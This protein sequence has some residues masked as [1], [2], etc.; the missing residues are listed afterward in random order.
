MQA[1]VVDNGGDDAAAEPGSP[2]AGLGDALKDQSTHSESQHDHDMD[3]GFAKSNEDG[4]AAE[5]D[6]HDEQEEEEKNQEADEQPEQKDMDESETAEV[7]AAKQ[8]WKADL[9]VL[10][11]D[12]VVVLRIIRRARSP[13]VTKVLLNSPLLFH[14]RKRVS[15]A[16]C[17]IIPQ[18]VCGPKLF[19]PCTGVQL[20]ELK[21]AGFEL[22]DH[23]ILAL[24]ED[25]AL[26]NRA[27]KDSLPKKSSTRVTS[28]H[29]SAAGQAVQ[30]PE[31]YA[32]SKNEGDDDVDFVV[33]EGGYAT[34]SDIGFP[35]YEELEVQ[36]MPSASSTIE[37]SP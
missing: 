36:A 13:L 14:C 9:P 37:A 28:E 26:I 6:E 7:L 12:N 33:E 8:A 25:K 4:V 27:F 21:E 20:E 10:S 2:V 29:G 15:D 19:V 5:K 17:E 30:D 22:L 18:G 3:K 32:H 1:N 34:D 35:A 23:H 31:G 16:G 11:G 24:R